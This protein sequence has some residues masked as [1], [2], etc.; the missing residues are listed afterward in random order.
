MNKLLLGT[1]ALAAIVAVPGVSLAATFAY[2]NTV[3][4][5]LTVESVTP[6]QAIVTAPGIHTNSGVMLIEVAAD[7]EMIGDRVPV[8]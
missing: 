2:V 4:E 8:Q 1:F 6:A 3:G 7:E 5:V